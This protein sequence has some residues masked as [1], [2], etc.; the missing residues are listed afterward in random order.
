M[1]ARAEAP[2]FGTT[3]PSEGASDFVR[4][5]LRGR[6]FK[7]DL[8]IALFV[9]ILLTLTNHYDVVLGGQLRV[10]I[11]VKICL[12]FVIPFVVSSISAYANRCG[13]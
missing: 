2:P 4:Y 10:N 3:I 13:S 8:L 7:R 12:N 6:V 5:A 11:L 9:G 1:R